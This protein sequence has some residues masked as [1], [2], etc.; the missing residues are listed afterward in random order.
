MG[1]SPFSDVLVLAVLIM[2]TR[3]RYNE[4]NRGGTCS[5]FESVA[6]R[7]YPYPD[8]SGPW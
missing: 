8:G 5:H 7:C 3:A 2:L 4:T 6:E 1:I